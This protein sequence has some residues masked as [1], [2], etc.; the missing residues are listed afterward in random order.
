MKINE[1]QNYIGRQ[2]FKITDHAF[3]KMRAE[4][5]TFQNIIAGIMNGEII[6]EYP[7]EYPL[8]ACLI[9]G[10]TETAEPI[11]ICIS[12]P[13]LVKI[14]TVYRP[15][16][17]KWLDNFQ[18]RKGGNMKNIC[19]FCKGDIH[20]QMVTVI[21]EYEGDVFIIENVP[22]GVC[23][24]CG[25]REYSATVASKLELILKKRKAIQKE[26]LVPVADF[27]LV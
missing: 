4:Y 2:D 19:V 22:A 20:E 3:E 26:R 1:I 12:L 15:D 6:E 18:K 14:I 11:Y 23:T 24:Q 13:P 27:S 25:E 7:F 9:N 5:L 16:P 17:V 10:N 21:K 8:P